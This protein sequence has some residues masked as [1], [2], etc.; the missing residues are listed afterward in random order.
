MKNTVKR[1][2]FLDLVLEQMELADGLRPVTS[3]AMFGGHGLYLRGI[4]FG[5]VYKRAL[6]FKVDGSTRDQYLKCGMSPFC[7]NAKQTLKSYYQVPAEVLEHPKTLAA[8]AAQAEKCARSG[9]R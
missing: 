6:Y 3:K 2:P 7:P 1:D 4:F 8:W 5:I 9:R